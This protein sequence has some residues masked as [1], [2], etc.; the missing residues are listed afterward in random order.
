MFCWYIDNLCHCGIA[1]MHSVLSWQPYQM[2]GGSCAGMLF[3]AT[4]MGGFTMQYVH[5]PSGL[6][7]FRNSKTTIEEDRSGRK[8]YLLYEELEGVRPLPTLRAV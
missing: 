2:R 3:V 1:G 7:G 4:S 5:L 6:T 8:V